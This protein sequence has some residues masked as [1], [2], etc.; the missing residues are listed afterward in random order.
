MAL[1]KISGNQISPTTEA[2]ITNLSFLNQDSVLTLPSGTTAN[3]PTG[4]SF[5]TLR[6]NTEDDAA[7]IYLAD[8]GQGSPGWTDVGGGGTSLGNNGI[9]RCNS[10][11]IEENID[12]DPATLGDEYTNAFCAGPI[13]VSQGYEVTVRNG[14]NFYVLG[15]Q[16]ADSSFTNL[17]VFGTLNTHNGML[18]TAAIREN[19]RSYRAAGTDTEITI[20]YSTASAVYVSNIGA[21][22]SINITNLPTSAIGE[23]QADNN[24]AFAFTIMYY[25]TSNV[26]PTG[27]IKIDGGSNFNAVWQGGGAPNQSQL[28]ANKYAV[29]GVAL[30]RHTEYGASSNSTGWKCFLQFNEYGT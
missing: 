23:G 9:I 24:K 4:I 26:I 27:T 15:E 29:V 17:T 7:E 25:N 16:P 22:Y 12:I 2:I 20:D 13:E 6:Y 28:Q 5:G 14:A 11:T 18:D 21:N 1:T 3:Q 10:D 8:S 19:L 30:I